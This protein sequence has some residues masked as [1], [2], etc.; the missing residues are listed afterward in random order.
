MKAKW[1]PTAAPCAPLLLSLVVLLLDGNLVAQSP[2]GTPDPSLPPP[3]LT[4]HGL[5]PGVSTMAEVRE[6]LGAPAHEARWYDYKML[7]PVPDR[8]GL[9]DAVHLEARDAKTGTL[10]GV[11][12]ATIPE[13]WGIWSVVRARLGPPEFY[14]ELHDHALA[15]YTEKGLRFVFDHWGH[16]IGIAYVPHGRPRVHAGGRRF[17]SLRHLRQGAQ[18]TLPTRPGLDGLRAGAVEVDITPTQ[19]ALGPSAADRE[20]RVHDPIKAR[21]AVLERGNLCVAIVGAD[22]FG[23]SRSEV[24][25]IEAGLREHGVDHLILASSHNHSAPDTIGIYGFFPQEYVA[26]VQRKIRD[27][28]LAAKKASRAVKAWRAASD[29]LPLRGARVAGLFRN[30]RNPGIVDP[31]IAVLQAVGADDRPIATFVHFAC[32]V[33]GLE[34]GAIEA[35]AGFPGVLCDRIAR[36]LGGVAIFLNGA[37]GGMIT[38]DTAARTQEE[39]RMAGV[40]LA[41]EVKRIRA[42]AVA[43][44][45][46]RF[47]IIRR[48]VEIPLTNPK[49]HLFIKASGRR[50]LHESRLV[51]EMFLLRLGDAEIITMPGELLPE[52]SFEIL[53]EMQGYPRMIVGLVNDECGYLI[54]AWDFNPDQ[55]EESMSPGPAAGPVVRDQAIRMLRESRNP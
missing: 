39:T 9:F 32:H 51:T 23:L 28:V 45:E 37:V 53:A 31:Q 17:L 48:R 54:P 1:L 46:M 36:D 55:Y 42:L 40:R 27:G 13:G 26:D 18:A 50:T 12:A 24:L 21:C 5:I 30:A 44:S 29:E 11:E 52:L 22:L 41:E 25:P 8:P 33:E 49:L 7:Y 20:F 47:E 3:A 34:K 4:Y 15:D 43:P 10:G 2:F 6:K 16:T 19:E 38:G 35:S 14:L